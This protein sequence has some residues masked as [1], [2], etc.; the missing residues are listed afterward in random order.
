MIVQDHLPDSIVLKYSL[1]TLAARQLLVSLPAINTALESESRIS[2]DD[3]FRI[4]DLSIHSVLTEAI[5]VDVEQ[6]A[7]LLT[8]LIESRAM[9]VGTYNPS[10]QAAFCNLAQGVRENASVWNF[11]EDIERYHRQ[12]N[13]LAVLFYAGADSEQL[14][15]CLENK[16]SLRLE[17]ENG[18]FPPVA[19]HFRDKTI[20]VRFN[21][22][23]G[24][25]D[26]LSYLFL[27]LHEYV[28]HV[29]L[30]PNLASDLFQDGW[31]LYAAYAFL[32]RRWIIIAEEHTIYPDQVDI[33]EQH[34]L[35]L[36][37]EIRSRASYY[38]AQQIHQQVPDVFFALTKALAGYSYTENGSAFS[39]DNFVQLLRRNWETRRFYTTEL[40]RSILD[41]NEL[42]R[43]L[44]RQY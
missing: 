20:A 1:F 11:A 27:L 19:T 9:L 36:L 40:L 7:Q 14:Q 23:Q 22:K 32:R 43:G 29:F 26:Y 33:V 21:F 18:T 35:P 38:F 24:I 41:I 8:H 4:F 25:A 2:K 5:L 42:T 30:P 44:E 28:S 39:L 3:V 13:Q 16:F 10:L 15:L 17:W 34:L 37:D 12:A 31:L 6:G